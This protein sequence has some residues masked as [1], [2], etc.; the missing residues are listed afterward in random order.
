MLSIMCCIA[1]GI[2]HRKPRAH[3]DKEQHQQHEDQQLH[4]YVVGNRRLGMGR[5]QMKRPRIAFATPARYLFRSAVIQSCSGMN[6][7]SY[8][9]NLVLRLCRWHTLGIR[10][11]SASNDVLGKSESASQRNEY[12]DCDFAGHG[13]NRKAYTAQETVKRLQEKH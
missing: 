4:G 1:P 12:L 7:Y 2:V 10:R 11:Y 5:V 3:D 8:K 13:G 9:P 6:A